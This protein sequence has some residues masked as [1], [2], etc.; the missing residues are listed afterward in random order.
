MLKGY[1]VFIC[2]KTFEDVVSKQAYLKACKWLAVNVYGSEGYSE[3]IFVQLKKIPKE[4]AD[5][6][7]KFTVKLYYSI[8]FESVQQIHCNNCKLAVNTFFGEQPICHSCKMT[9][10]LKKLNHDTEF[11]VEKLKKEFTNEE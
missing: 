2:E 4:K 1:S 6:K 11:I 5:E 10:F 8:N 3:N 9:P 7:F